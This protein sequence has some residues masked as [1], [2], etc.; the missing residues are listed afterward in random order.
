TGGTGIA[1]QR[2][3]DVGRK[4]TLGLEL[5]LVITRRR[6]T[7]DQRALID[8]LLRTR[9]LRLVVLPGRCTAADLAIGLG[10]T[11]GFAIAVPRA[12]GT[13]STIR[14]IGDGKGTFDAHL[15]TRSGI[16]RL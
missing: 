16:G 3:G 1:G 8:P 7:F 15:S 2:L 5:G 11:L 6:V 10:D 13:G 9:G 4:G 12:A 14:G